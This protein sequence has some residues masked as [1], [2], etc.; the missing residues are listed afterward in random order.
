[1]IAGLVGFGGEFPEHQ[2]VLVGRGLYDRLTPDELHFV[3]AHELVHLKRN[4]PKE[5]YRLAELRQAA[6][7]MGLDSQSAARTP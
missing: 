7:A 6:K 4:P 3:L 1:L 2:R 5:A